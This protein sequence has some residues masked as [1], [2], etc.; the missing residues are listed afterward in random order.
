M[1]KIYII[2]SNDIHK[3][4]LAND[5]DIDNLLNK[6]FDINLSNEETPLLENNKSRDIVTL[7][8]SIQTLVEIYE[9]L[10]YLKEVFELINMTKARYLKVYK[11]TKNKKDTK[12][13]KVINLDDEDYIDQIKK[14]LEKSTDYIFEFITSEE[15]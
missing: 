2:L 7:I 3:N 12:V 15:N 8:D 6:K 9:I 13:E 5:F 10:D 14:V 4:L 1:S 11:K